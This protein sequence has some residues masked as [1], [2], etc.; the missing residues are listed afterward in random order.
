MLQSTT[1][2]IRSKS[3]KPIKDKYDKKLVALTGQEKYNYFQGKKK[4][5][6]Q[7]GDDDF[8]DESFDEKDIEI[9]TKLKKDVK[10]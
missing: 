3:M 8:E 1:K 2:M 9:F 10:M 4:G 5:D 6:V 7:F